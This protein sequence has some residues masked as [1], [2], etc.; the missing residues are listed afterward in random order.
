MCFLFGKIPGSDSS[1]FLPI[2]IVWPVVLALKCLKSLGRC[3]S[4]SL[5]LPNSLFLPMAAIN[6]IMDE[7]CYGLYLHQYLPPNRCWFQA[8]DS[9]SLSFFRRLDIPF[10]PFSV[11]QE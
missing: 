11:G 9:L 6:V 5:S 3:Q 4:I 7:I 8:S 2:T 10:L 1:V